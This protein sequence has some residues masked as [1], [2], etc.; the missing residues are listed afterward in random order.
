[1][2]MKLKSFL[3]I[4]LTIT[5]LFGTAAPAF[6]TAYAGNVDQVETI[7]VGFFHFDGY[8]DISDRGDRSGYGYQFLR[9][10][11]RYSSLNFE[12][13]GYDKSWSEM[14][15][16][17]DS[18]EIDMLTSMHYTPER[19]EKFDFSTFIGYSSTIMTVRSNNTD[20][21]TE[22]YTDFE[23]MKIGFLNNNSRNERFR[24]YAEGIGFKYEPVMFEEQEDMTDALDAG[25]VDAIVSSNLRKLGQERIVEE[26][27]STKFYAAVKKGNKNLLS[28]IN[29]GIS[30]MDLY[31]GDWRNKLHSDNYN[32]RPLSEIIYSEKEQTFL[33]DYKKSG[34]KLKVYFIPDSEPYCFKKD[35][36]IAGIIPDIIRNLMEGTGLNYEFVAA[37]DPVEYKRIFEEGK[38][39]I[40]PAMVGTDSYADSKG[41]LMTDPYLTN[42]VSR[43][44]NKS[45]N[46]NTGRVGVPATAT[47]K[48]K[49]SIGDKMLVQYPSAKEVIEAVKSGEVDAGYVEHYSCQWLINEDNSNTLA[50]ESL[51]N[52]SYG[53]SIAVNQN[54]PHELC[55]ILNKNLLMITDVD[56]QTII[57]NHMVTPVQE[58][59]LRDYFEA[60]RSEFFLY[61]GIA[62]VVILLIIITAMLLHVNKMKRVNAQLRNVLD[63]YK[64]ADYDRRTDFLTELHNRQDMF[65]MFQELITDNEKTITALFMMDIDNFKRLNDRFGHIYGDECLKR[66]GAALN[67][68]GAENNMVFYRYGGEEMLG[69]SFSDEKKA[70]QIAE[71]LIQLVRDQDIK[72][73]DTPAGIVTVSLG[74]TT[75]NHRYE[76]MVEM[77]DAAMY[78]AK[79]NGK[80]QA[81]CYEKMV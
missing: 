35:G 73:D 52:I 80:N 46:S 6:T 47:Y 24:E 60:N 7:R 68:Y 12:Y 56:M 70:D 8:H 19:A 14:Q 22:N 49:L 33:N 69:I 21:K 61:A 58:L 17:L 18:G 74:Y 57:Q 55:S 9:L 13:V 67:T 3:A 28:K 44:Y 76:K 63:N 37:E 10:L 65:D 78:R 36:D 2:Y 50:T 64:Q 25:T 66:I 23:G 41:Y 20:I 42:Y 1:M 48:R 77:A 53:M 81:V 51:Q 43:V 34:K 38:A 11:S 15:E 30:Q 72:R 4:L 29:Y 27:G 75:N 79:E 26:F 59:S 32:V 31:E 39:D 45:L 40:A 16:M 54:L 5:I 71:E 62:V